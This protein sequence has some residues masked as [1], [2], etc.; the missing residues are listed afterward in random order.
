MLS[1]LTALRIADMDLLGRTDDKG[2]RPELDELLT[3]L[4]ATLPALSDAIT[5]TY[6][7]HL[8]TSRHLACS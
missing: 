2:R 5:Q 4:A 6:L 7:S 8:Q 3:R 1:S